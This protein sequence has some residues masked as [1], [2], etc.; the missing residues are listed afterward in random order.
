MKVLRSS[1]GGWGG[2]LAVG[3]MLSGCAS[4]NPDV[5]KNFQSSVEVGQRGLATEMARDVAWTREADVQDLA[6][7]KDAPLSAYVVKEAK[8]YDWTMETVPPHWE[9][10][11]T[12]KTLEDLNAAF[13]AYAA[14][15][16]HSAAGQLK[17]EAVFD[18]LADSLNGTLRE[19]KETLGG[20]QT[21]D[22]RPI[23]G[24]SAFVAESLRR[25]VEHRR[26]KDLAR[27]VR[28]N[29]PLVEDT[30]AQGRD[31]IGLIRADL[32]ASYADQ[33]QAIYDRWDDKRSP[34]RVTL[35]R[36]LFNL[37]EEYADAMDTLRSLEGFY[38][39]LPGAHRE[40]AEGIDRAPAP[41][42]ALAALRRSAE[43][44]ARRMKDLEKSR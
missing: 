10:R 25:Y 15:L 27:A 7:R 4:L 9:A 31:L 12:L 1:R 33:V 11:R 40:L 28:E 37:N 24:V 39:N 35:T 36:S 19:L 38:N 3:G 5:F 17:D 13:G 6:N 30:A 8:G 21:T 22:K 23:A 32:K 43:N 14:L 20:L 44:V 41:R 26:A 34:G 42:K 29:Q 2:V 16:S 18:G